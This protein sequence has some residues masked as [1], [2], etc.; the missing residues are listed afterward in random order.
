MPSEICGKCQHIFD[1]W[2][3]IVYDY[4]LGEDFVSYSHWENVTLF[5]NSAD[6]CHLCAQFLNQFS[7]GELADAAR[8]HEEI[9]SRLDIIMAPFLWTRHEFEDNWRLSLYLPLMEGPA[10]VEVSM[11]PTQRLGRHLARPRSI[12]NFNNIVLQISNFI[13]PYYH[14][15]NLRPHSLNRGNGLWSAPEPTRPVSS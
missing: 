3:H 4:E 1:E 12:F 14:Q 11:G 13:Y 6:N 2:D 5:K 15:R 9:A 7:D 10:I 8:S